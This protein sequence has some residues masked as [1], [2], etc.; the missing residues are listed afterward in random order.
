MAEY[1]A[2]HR[3]QDRLKRDAAREADPEK[4]QLI[5]LQR[6]IEAAEYMAIT[7]Q[8]LAGIGRVVAGRDDSPQV[9]QDEARHEEFAVRGRELREQYRELLEERL[10][11]DADPRRQQREGGASKGDS[12]GQPPS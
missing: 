11:R 9:Q 6:E 8:R 5:E 10:T 4:R 7:S 12:G 2:F 1:G 3:E